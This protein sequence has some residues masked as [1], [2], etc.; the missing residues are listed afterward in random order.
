MSSFTLSPW[1]QKLHD[2]RVTE[3]S[4]LKAGNFEFCTTADF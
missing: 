4:K 2:M 3:Y 1:L